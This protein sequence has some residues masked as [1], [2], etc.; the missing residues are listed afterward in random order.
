MTVLMTADSVGGVWTYALDLSRGL[1]ARGIRVVLAVMGAPLSIDQRRGADQV[2]GLTLAVRP[3]R[4]EWMDDPWDDVEEAGRWLLDL[5]RIWAPD[6]VHVNGFAHGALPFT[7][8]VL[9]AAHS[10]VL[11]WFREVKRAPASAEWLRYEQAVKRGLAG[12]RLIV[13][14]SRAMAL[15][16]IRHYAP[17]PPVIPIHNGRDASAYAPAVKEPL[18]LTA[19]RIWD[20]AKN[21]AQLA[22]VGPT[23]PWPIVAAGDGS[24]DVPGLTS[25]GRLTA[26]ALA[27]WYG[28]ASIYALPARYEPFGL[29]VVE[30]AMSGCALVLGDIPSLRELWDGAATFVDPDDPGALTEALT[31]LIADPSQRELMALLALDRAGHYTVEAMTDAYCAVYRQLA[32]TPSLSFRRRFACAS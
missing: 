29:S 5:A 32:S 23:I 16:V 8:P 27:S 3:Y 20:E 1:A 30:A 28:R 14:P 17:H 9:I 13:A 2:P 19:G 15:S 10:C 18:V 21:V 12:A 22:A 26:A 25:L 4:L 31:T 11:S 24:Q 7:A 6:V